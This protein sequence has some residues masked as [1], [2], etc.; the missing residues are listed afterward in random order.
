MGSTMTAA[1][2]AG[3]ENIFPRELIL[4]AG[5]ISRKNRIPAHSRTIPGGNGNLLFFNGK[6]YW[7]SSPSRKLLPLLSRSPPLLKS[8]NAGMGGNG[9]RGR[10][11]GE[12]K[13]RQPPSPIVKNLPRRRGSATTY[14]EP[15]GSTNRKGNPRNDL[16]PRNDRPVVRGL[17]CSLVVYLDHQGAG[18]T[19]SYFHVAELIAPRAE[20]TIG[21]AFAKAVAETTTEKEALD[22]AQRNV[23]RL[24]TRRLTQA[25]FV[26]RDM[27]SL[28][29]ELAA[30]LRTIESLARPTGQPVAMGGCANG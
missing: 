12:Q 23:A 13:P 3:R 8:G 21:G 5:K 6:V 24:Y 22:L 28:R 25:A 7:R 30:A 26:R 18:C 20:A 16:T 14:P 9:E 4:G 27:T 19:D 2:G 15:P 29:R 10:E 1:M 17:D 11:E